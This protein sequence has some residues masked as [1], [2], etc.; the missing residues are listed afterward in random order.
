MREVKKEAGGQGEKEGG[1][2]EVE[3]EQGEVEREQGEVEREGGEQGEEREGG[4]GARRGERVRGWRRGSGVRR[5]EGG[6]EEEERVRRG[7]ASPI[8]SCTPLPAPPALAIHR[9]PP[10]SHPQ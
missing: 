3:R 7:V 9:A 5:A 4:R 8:Y 1:V 2:R 6:G 10:T